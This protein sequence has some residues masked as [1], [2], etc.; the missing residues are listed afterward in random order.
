MVHTNVVEVGGNAVP[1]SPVPE[2]PAP[3][4]P[5]VPVPLVATPVVPEPELPAT[6]VEVDEVAGTRSVGSTPVPGVITFGVDVKARIEMSPV[7]LVNRRVS[8][9]TPSI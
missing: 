1:V 5:E 9:P 4:V 6:L 2:F 7:V 3:L 8:G